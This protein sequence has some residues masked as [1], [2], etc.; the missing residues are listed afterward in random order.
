MGKKL[1]LV[2]GLATGYVLG[3][4]AG[5]TRYNQIASAASRFWNSSPV[6]KQV[7]NVE[8]FAKDKAPEVVDFARDQAKKVTGK[9]G[10]KS[11]SGTGSLS[12]N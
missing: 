7:H 11:K 12:S 6:Q 3:A 1:M 2:A 8:D 9:S 4:R 5:R 10:K